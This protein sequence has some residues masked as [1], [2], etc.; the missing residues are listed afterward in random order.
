MRRSLV[1]GAARGRSK[2]MKY[3][4][5]KRHPALTPLSREHF[6]GLVQVRRLRRAADADAEQRRQVLAGFI[7]HWSTEMTAHFDDEERLLVPLAS[8]PDGQRLL[9][10][11][12]Q[13]RALAEAARPRATAAEPGIDWM[14]ALAAILER[15][16]RW[17]E[18][19]FFE[20]LQQQVRAEDLAALLPAAQTIERT[21]P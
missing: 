3:P 6:N 7:A 11:H 12:A 4:P 18:R 9:A 21:R 13:L 15:H 16:I 17:E 1:S 5:L 19:E 2:T 20:R 8:A 14:R 10:E